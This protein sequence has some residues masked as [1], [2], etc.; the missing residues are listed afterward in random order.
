[1][2]SSVKVREN[3][4]L[5]KRVVMKTSSACFEVLC[6]NSP[7]QTKGNHKILHTGLWLSRS[8]LEPDACLMQV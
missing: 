5:V 1:M 7:G 4:I 2:L 3:I 8:T 6:R